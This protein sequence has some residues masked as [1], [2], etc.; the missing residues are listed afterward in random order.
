MRREE[1]AVGASAGMKCPVSGIVA[2]LDRPGVGHL[3][4]EADELG[5][6]GACYGPDRDGDSRERAPVAR[7][8]ARPH[9]SERRRQP[10]GVVVDDAVG[11]ELLPE[12]VG[13]AGPERRPVPLLDEGGEV[14]LDRGGALGVRGAAGGALGLGAQAG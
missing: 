6:E 5:V 10:G 12:R 2:G 11:R 3:V 9:A 4:S 7:L 13:Q 14:G 1:S 8:G